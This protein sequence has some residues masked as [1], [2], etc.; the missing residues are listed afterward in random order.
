M[1]TE[2]KQQRIINTIKINTWYLRNLKT[3]KTKDAVLKFNWLD[4]L[5]RKVASVW[6]NSSWY[7]LDDVVEERVYALAIFEETHAF[8]A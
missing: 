6:N 7:L 5:W 2:L 8:E 4:G 3:N 1:T